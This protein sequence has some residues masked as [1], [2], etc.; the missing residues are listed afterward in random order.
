MVDLQ[1]TALI[2]LATA[3]KLQTQASYTEVSGATSQTDLPRTIAESDTAE[4]AVG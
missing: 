4:Y 3:P 1:S 2:H